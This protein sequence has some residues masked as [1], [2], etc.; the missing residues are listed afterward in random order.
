MAK[1]KKWESQAVETKDND[2]IVVSMDGDEV[3]LS[4]CWAGSCSTTVFWERE[5]L[6]EVLEGVVAFLREGRQ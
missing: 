6:I 1:T 5:E 2:S 4:S 3:R